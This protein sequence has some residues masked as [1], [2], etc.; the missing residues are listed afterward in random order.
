MAIIIWHFCSMASQKCWLTRSSGIDTISKE[1]VKEPAFAV[2]LG[3][4]LPAGSFLCSS[5][6]LESLKYS[7]YSA[8][9]VFPLEPVKENFSLTSTFCCANL[10]TEIGVTPQLG[11][12]STGSFWCRR[13]GSSQSHFYC[14]FSQGISTA[15]YR[16][17]IA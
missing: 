16:Q 8:V 10:S 7:Y 3:D 13:C 6:T 12:T 4:K 15:S 2:I 17:A 5:C 9:M 14:K 1:P 11:C